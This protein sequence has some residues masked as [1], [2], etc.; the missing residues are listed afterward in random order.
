MK[1]YYGS[2]LLLFDPVYIPLDPGDCM[3]NTMQ[4]A[5][6]NLHDLTGFSC[7]TTDDECTSIRC[8]VSDSSAQSLPLQSVGMSVRPCDDPPSL[9]LSVAVNGDTQPITADDNK[10]VS[11]SHLD[12]KLRI[13][14][15]HFDY[16]MDVEVSIHTHEREPLSLGHVK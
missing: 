1:D 13:S 15:W 6:D 10:V 14:V 11:L 8:D 4:E 2:P 12:A 9:I 7:D 16:S 3:C 5:A